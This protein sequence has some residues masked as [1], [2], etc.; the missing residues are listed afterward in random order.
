MSYIILPIKFPIKN[1]VERET[2]WSAPQNFIPFPVKTTDWEDT[3]LVSCPLD[4]LEEGD[5]LAEF[6]H[7]VVEH[8]GYH[9]ISLNM[10]AFRQM[11]PDGDVYA[12]EET[13]SSNNQTINNNVQ[14][15]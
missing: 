8:I 11:Y 10:E 15:E 5:D 2:F 4:L 14:N 9:Y 6:V 7:T 12:V 13:D 1:V 3:L